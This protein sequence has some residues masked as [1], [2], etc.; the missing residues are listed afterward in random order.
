MKRKIVCTLRPTK[1]DPEWVEIIDVLARSA[2]GLV[3]EKLTKLIT[4]VTV[5][6]KATDFDDV[7]GLYVEYCIHKKAYKVV[8]GLAEDKLDGQEM[9]L[10]EIIKSLNERVDDSSDESSSEN[11]YPLVVNGRCRKFM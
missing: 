10:D 11:E 8:I 2:Q 7:Q 4:G 3:E 9:A 5:E 6:P 1:P